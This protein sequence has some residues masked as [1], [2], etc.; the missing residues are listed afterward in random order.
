MVNFHPK[1][2]IHRAVISD[3]AGF[4]QC[5]NAQ[6]LCSCFLCSIAQPRRPQES[7]GALMS[8]KPGQTRDYNHI[9]SYN[10]VKTCLNSNQSTLPPSTRVRVMGLSC[11]WPQ[12]ETETAHL[13]MS[14]S[15]WPRSNEH[16]A[17]SALADN[18][19]GD[20][21]LLRLMLIVVPRCS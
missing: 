3:S 14:S 8:F 13:E 16:E 19:L 1:P 15:E 5:A 21:D 10:N 11:E 18:G 17:S 9:T 4:L 7:F 20:G 12:C 2:M 6:E